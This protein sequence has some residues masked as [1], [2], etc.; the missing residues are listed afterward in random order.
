MQLWRLK[1]VGALFTFLMHY[2][3]QIVRMYK[4][5][6]QNI[7]KIPLKSNILKWKFNWQE[8]SY[9]MWAKNSMILMWN[10]KDRLSFFFQSFRNTAPSH[11]EHPE[12][13]CELWMTVALARWQ[14]MIDHNTSI[15]SSYLCQCMCLSRGKKIRRRSSRTRFPRT[16]FKK[17]TRGKD[18]SWWSFARFRSRFIVALNVQHNLRFYSSWNIEDQEE[19][20]N[21][22]RAR[23]NINC[24][25]LI[26][27][28]Q[29]E[30]VVRRMWFPRYLSYRRGNRF[31]KICA[32]FTVE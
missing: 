18:R 20:K 22:R 8:Q 29:Y 24:F 2:I 25:A 15:S 30:S 14:H 7:W 1:K 12:F 17:Q 19:E 21:G 6:T 4:N 13:Y 28:K 10:V 3:K 31:E 27:I 26:K 5:F 32:A 11:E 23:D 16:R 9:H